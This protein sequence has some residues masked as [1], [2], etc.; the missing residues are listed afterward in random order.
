MLDLIEINDH[1]T[2]AFLS[3]SVGIPPQLRYLVWPILLKYHPMCISPNLVPNTL[4]WDTTSHCYVPEKPPS[5]KNNDNVAKTSNE[6]KV[7]TD[8]DNANNDKNVKNHNLENKTDSNETTSIEEVVLKDLKKYFHI[9]ISH[10][11]KD[12]KSK[13]FFHNS[14]SSNS[15]SNIDERVIISL[16]DSIM[17]F[18]NKWSEICKYEHGMSGIAVGLAEWVPISILNN[19]TDPYV[20]ITSKKISRPTPSS[21]SSTSSSSSSPTSDTNQNDD[22][23]NSSNELH[24]SIFLSPLFLEYPLPKHLQEKLN[25]VSSSSNIP[26]FSFDEIFERLVLIL[27]NSPDIELAFEM[28]Q[29][30]ASTSNTFLYSNTNNNN[31]NGNNNNNNNYFP[32]ISGGDTSFKTQLFFKVFSSILPELYQPLTEET[33]LHSY[34][35]KNWIYWWIKCCGANVLH[36]QDRARIWDLM[37]GWRPYP[38]LHSINFYLNYNSKKFDQFYS[39]FPK[40]NDDI[41][42]ISKFANFNN[43][44]FWF[45]DLNTIPLGSRNFETDSKVFQEL[46]MRN[47]ADKQNN[48][49]DL[50]KNPN[51]L[52]FSLLS[53]HTQ[54]IF[55]YVAIFQHF[56]SKLLEFEDTEINEF[57]MNVPLITKSENLSYK[58][59]IDLEPL[60]STTSNTESISTTESGPAMSTAVQITSASSSSSNAANSNVNTISNTNNNGTSTTTGNH[61]SIELG[62]D[63]KLSHSFNDILNVAGDI[64]RMW[65]W[66]DLEDSSQSAQ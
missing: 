2:L 16:K 18:V 4:L 49:F 37:L 39:K 35:S 25:S 34:S 59:L 57:L 30:L 20:L 46:L 62:S 12:D 24:N 33:S 48:I 21:S 1:D 45:P 66:K 7:S 10:S 14:L 53:P 27:F 63:G 15:I 55:I 61:M 9:R 50:N 47:E 8:N 6:I 3:R 26:I 31:N 23:G 28:C 36:K 56:E 38:N 42:T 51:E 40:C 11:S 43:D 64:W 13:D 29:N 19:K 41:K 17:K 52:P 65:M 44:T 54:I 60:S 58:T 22:T 5:D 32:I